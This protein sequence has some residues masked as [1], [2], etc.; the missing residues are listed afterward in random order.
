MECA[1]ASTAI[2]EAFPVPTTRR[3]AL[4]VLEDDLGCPHLG[5]TDRVLHV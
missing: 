3:G 5:G 2:L 4:I 1:G